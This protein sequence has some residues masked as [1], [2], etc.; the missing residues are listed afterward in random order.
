MERSRVEG[1]EERYCLPN[2]YVRYVWQWGIH[3][4][5]ERIEWGSGEGKIE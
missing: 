5:G 3:G 2:E 1:E 4:R